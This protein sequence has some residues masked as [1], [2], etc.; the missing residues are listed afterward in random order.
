MINFEISDLPLTENQLLNCKYYLK[1]DY[2]P[3]SQQKIVVIKFEEIDPAKTTNE[4]NRALR[5]SNARPYLGRSCHLCEHTDEAYAS[6]NQK[7]CVMWC[8]SCGRRFYQGYDITD[9]SCWKPPMDI[10]EESMRDDAEA[11]L[12]KAGLQY[13]ASEIKE[14]TSSDIDCTEIQDKL[15][16]LDEHFQKSSDIFYDPVTKQLTWT[17]PEI[18]ALIKTTITPAGF[19]FIVA[20][21]SIIL[22]IGAF[23]Y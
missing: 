2:H 7:G 15:A 9:Y 12:F 10:P 17:H 3:S 14:Y 19:A 21:L 5:L 23:L 18:K 4:A 22:C 20:G 11:V 6:T 16:L 13:M 8:M 1:K